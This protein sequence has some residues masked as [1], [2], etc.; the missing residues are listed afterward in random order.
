MV[1]HGKSWKNHGIML[2]NFCGNPVFCSLYGHIVC[3][4]AIREGPLSSSSV[5]LSISC[6]VFIIHSGT[7]IIA[8]VWLHLFQICV[9]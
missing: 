4:E 9:Q 2:L 3:H 8:T 1:D 7:N 6:N 5:C